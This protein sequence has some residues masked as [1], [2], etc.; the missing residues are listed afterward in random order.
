[1]TLD[2]FLRGLHSKRKLDFSGIL[3]TYVR[4]GRLLS[5]MKIASEMFR[6]SVNKI[7]EI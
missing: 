5:N 2:S 6:I 1:M 4:Q 7:A 3:F